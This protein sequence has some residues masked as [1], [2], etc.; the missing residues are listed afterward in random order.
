MS[1]LRN[2][3]SNG[4]RMLAP[5][6]LSAVLFSC[7]KE[8]L[9][10]P[11]Q[12]GSDPLSLSANTGAFANSTNSIS[13]NIIY[14][15]NFEGSTVWDGLHKQ[16]GTSHAFNVVNSPVFEG[17]KVGRYELRYD[18]PIQSGGKR[19]EVLFPE[20]KNMHR[21]YSMAVYF[22]SEHYGKDSYTELINQWHQSGG[23]PSIALEI[24][25]D[26]Y[27]LVMPAAAAK[28][29]NTVRLDLGAIKKDIWN[30][31]VWHI[32]HSTGSDGLIQLWVNGT[33]ILDRRGPNMHSLDYASY[34]PK[35]KV[36]IYKWKWNDDQPTDVKKRVL[37]FDDV[38]VGNENATY[39]EMTSGTSTSAPVETPSEPTPAPETNEP[40][41]PDADEQVPTVPETTTPTSPS[42]GVIQSF[43]LINA[44]TDKDVTT[45][46]NG[47]TISLSKIG[48]TKFNIRANTASGVASVNFA[49]SGLQSRNYTDRQFPFSVQGDSGTGNYYY[50]KWAAPA[51]YGTYTLKVTPYADARATSAI[52]APTTITFTIVK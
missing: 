9:M 45:V 44:S 52:G 26:H 1:G 5:L 32:N 18:D 40:T 3:L 12:D 47:A 36:G 48:V 28:T 31:I 43:T 51:A 27:N 6:F 34:S 38:R 8:S 21:W 49:L 17:S 24:K 29:S 37:F 50:G 10:E 4:K 30:R 42:N 23:S 2:H 7:S 35:W 19:S 16:F 39:A 46:T 15:E 41:A 14:R 22:P 20:Q 25:N 11:S 33:K 13:P